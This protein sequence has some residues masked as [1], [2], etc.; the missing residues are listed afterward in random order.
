MHE[1]GE[2]E[3]EEDDDD[4]ELLLTAMRMTTTTTVT[5]IPDTAIPVDAWPNLLAAAGSDA[6]VLLATMASMKAMNP[7]SGL[8]HQKTMHAKL[9][10][11]EKD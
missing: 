9:I 10:C 4:D 6:A 1:E 2:Y 7:K 11:D 8:Q 3:E 5:I